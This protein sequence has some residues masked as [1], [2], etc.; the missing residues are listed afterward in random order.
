VDPHWIFCSA[1]AASP[2]LQDAIVTLLD[3]HERR[4]AA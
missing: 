1:L 3:Q 4:D 2:N